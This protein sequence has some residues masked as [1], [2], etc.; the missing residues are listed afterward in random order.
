MQNNPS[1]ETV[2][3]KSHS[4]SPIWF[5]PFIAAILGAW[6]LFQNI[7]HKNEHITIHF[8]NADSIIVDKTKI[9]YKGV[10]VGTVKKIELDEVDGVNVF[11]E[12]E[13][14]ATFLLKEKSQFWLVSPKAS[15]T[16]I[17]GLDTLFSGSYINL[18]PGEGEAATTFEATTE[19][20]EI[21]PDNALLI[22][23]KSNNAASINIGTPI[24][25]KKIQV[26]EI[27]RVRL[28]KSG[29][30]VNIQAFI[31]SK[32]SHLI[33]KESQF[34][35]ISGLNANISRSGVDIK[36]DSLTSLI[37]GGITFS[38]PDSDTPPVKD[39]QFN[40]FENIDESKQ[41]LQITLKLTNTDN[42]PNGAGILF[43]GHGIGRI[44]HIRYD[45]DSQLF[46]AQATINPAFSE[47]VTENAQFWIEK[48]SIS[49]SKIENLS[50]LITGDYV[51]F[52]YSENYKQEKQK[53]EFVLNNNQLPSQEY[54][55]ITLIA[56][57]ANGLTAG[58]SVT[59]KGLKIGNITSLT[60]TKDSKHIKAML[61]INKQFSYLINKNSKF[62]LLSGVNFKASLQGIEVNSKPLKNILLGGI[63]LYNKYP[64]TKKNSKTP[65]KTNQ[66]FHLYA[67]KEMAKLGKNVF[68]APLKVSL[69]SKELPSVSVGSPVYYHKLKV[70]EVSDLTLHDSGLMQTSLEVSAQFKHL[71]TNKTV[72]WNI[73]GFQVDA[74]LS[75]VKVNAESLLSIAAGG[76]AL[77]LAPSVKG[78][79]TSQGQ[80]RLF[81][82][83]QQATI[84]PKQLTL[85]YDNAFDLKVGNKVKLKG[86]DIGEISNLTLNKHNKIDVTLDIDAKYFAKVAKKGS[87]FWIVRSDISLSGAKNLS[88]LI[89]GVFINVSP[90]T[91]NALT[92]FTGESHEPLLAQ[93][94]TGLPITLLADNA[95]STDI[96]SPVYYRQ[97]QIGEVINKRLNSDASGVEIELNIYPEYAYLIRSNSVFWPASGFNL[98]VGITGAALKATSLTSLIKGG[99]NMSTPDDEK[100]QPASK[101]FA[102]FELQSESKNSWLKWKLK[103][104]KSN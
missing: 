11:A 55:S 20:P 52:S 43:K 23:L 18:L 19:Q 95:G 69:L 44:N 99:I 60:L 98:D 27:V 73:S 40:L 90:G 102:S 101:A 64:P 103:I 63:A 54:A 97:I 84:P 35:N 72:F 8:S 71:I 61:N 48:A 17:S 66:L 104:P 29:K 59:Y 45:T 79:V 100:L 67:S 74:G 25:F 37:A 49:F 46:I 70:G 5:L 24:F 96:S 2:I 93:N 28:D 85:T 41:G 34:W 6:I 12:I 42:L 92:K 30:F 22:N 14:H 7:T 31:E 39:Q 88:T 68:T 86:L 89:S 91:G 78:N 51:G 77:E 38:S 58:A 36:L 65:L 32:Y 10:I 81:D 76:I 33:K 62:H 13:S 21:I 82:S 57:N 80:Y 83:Y 26:G 47:M 94:K 4:I 50:N 75:G 53:T 56:D 16:S 15:L 9:R 87:R 3:T 1:S